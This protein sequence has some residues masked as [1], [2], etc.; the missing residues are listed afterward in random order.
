MIGLTLLVLWFVCSVLA[1]G[2][3]KN[4]WRA[5][6]VQNYLLGY[7]YQEELLCWRFALLG[8]AGLLAV[9]ILVFSQKELIGLCYL[10]PRDLIEGTKEFKK[11]KDLVT[12]IRIKS[13]FA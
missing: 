9:L 3:H 2:F 5:F 13:L 7:G 4:S 8:P 1:Y 12:K 11:R 6:F 10:M